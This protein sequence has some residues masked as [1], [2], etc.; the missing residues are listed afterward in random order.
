MEDITES[1]YHSLVLVLCAIIHKNGGEL[2]LDAED[3]DGAVAEGKALEM[4]QG[5]DLNVIFRLVDADE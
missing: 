4:T 2:T 1:D 3:I 5:E